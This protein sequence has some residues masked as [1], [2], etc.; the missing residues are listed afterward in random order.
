MASD[1]ESEVGE[2]KEIVEEERVEEIAKDEE[3]VT[4]SKEGRQ[5]EEPEE[6][7]V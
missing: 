4:G 5:E 6:P 2:A 1:A 3:V 7:K